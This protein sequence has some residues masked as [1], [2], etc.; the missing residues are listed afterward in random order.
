MPERPPPGD[1][2]DQ[3]LSTA[4]VDDEFNEGRDD[5]DSAVWGDGD[6]KARFQGMTR[7]ATDLPA[8]SLAPCSGQEE[9]KVDKAADKARADVKAT[10]EADAKAAAALVKEREAREAAI[11]AYIYAY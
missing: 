6:S 7:A 2:L 10:A 1:E 5:R 9:A 4:P 8:S 11:G 3:G